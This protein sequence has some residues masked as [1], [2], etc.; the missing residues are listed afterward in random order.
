MVTVYGQ[1]ESLTRIK[2]TL[3]QKGIDR[4][5]S[6]GDIKKFKLRY[7]LERQDI[8]HQVEQD[9]TF[10][11]ENLQTNKIK[12]QKLFDNLKAKE[13]KKLLGK[14]TTLKTKLDTINSTA[15]N[16][17]II[18]IVNRFQLLILKFRINKLEKHFDATIA[19][20]TYNTRSRLDSTNEKLQKYT[21]NKEKIIEQ[22]SSPMLRKLAYT[23]QVIE[24]LEPLIAGA[25][26]ENLV[27]KEL[28]KLTGKN[29]LF[30]DFSMQFTPPI[31]N[32]EENDRIFSI[33]I[34]HLL[35]T[36]AGIFIIETKNWS[37]TS[38][39]SLDLRSPVKQIKRTNYALFV[40]LNSDSHQKGIGLNHHH[41]GAK[42]LPIRNIVA[43]INAKP[44]EEFSHVQVKTLKE[45]NN[46]ITYFEPI[47][48]DNEVYRISEYLK[49]IKN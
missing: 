8:S 17:L 38:I 12:F 40:M 25:I 14:I 7:E 39:E 43:M 41:W 44:K 10:E 26:G 16:N 20:K 37:K 3:H 21:V 23:K 18:R 15:T 22:R 4:F 47:F 33:Q 30:N 6:I 5:N 27:E 9:V 13:I 35:V 49:M 34:D 1:I 32:R 45:L 46:Y 36:N 24:N 11:I 42:K 28:K 19:L 29:I 31:Y 48:E 2:E